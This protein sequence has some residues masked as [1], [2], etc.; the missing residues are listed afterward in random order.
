MAV[1]IKLALFALIVALNAFSALEASN[2][3]GLLTRNLAEQGTIQGVINN[4]AGQRLVNA[5]A[6]FY[7]PNGEIIDSV[8][9]DSNGL[10]DIS[11]PTG[12]YRVSA[13][14]DG[15][16]KE[17]YPNSYFYSGSTVIKLFSKQNIQISISLKEGGLING[18]IATHNPRANNCIVSAIKLDNPYINWQCDKQVNISENGEYRLGGLLAGHYRVFIRAQG[19][20][21]QYYPMVQDYNEAAIISIS[22][23]Q[24]VNNI[25]FD[26]IPPAY[27]QISGRVMDTGSNRP[28][29]DISI[30]ASQWSP[31]LNDPGICVALTDDNGFYQFETV[32]GDYVISA[33][34]GGVQLTDG[35]FRI[36]YDGRFSKD[37]AD[38]VALQSGQV[39]DNINLN[40]DYNRNYNLQIS[41]ALFDED[42]GAPI[43]GA[44]M[45]ALDY[46]TGRA[47]SSGATENSGDFLIRN[48]PD[49]TYLIQITGS[50]LI[51]V[52]WPGVWGW[53]QAEKIRVSG[54]S[55][56]L[57]NGGAITQDYG[58]P[59]L[60]ISG[61]VECPDSNLAN[62]RIYAINV[63]NDM[64]AF[65]KTDNFGNY[66]LS[67]GLTEGAYN[68][69]ADLY[70]F[71][72]TYYPGIVAIDLIDNPQVENINFMLIPTFLGIDENP[73]L[74]QRDELLTN[75]PNPFNGGTK[76]MFESKNDGQVNFEVY[77]IAGRLCRILS[78]SVKP[79]INEI[80]WDGR[81]HRGNIVASGIYFYRVAGT[82][83]VRKMSL[84]K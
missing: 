49:G 78:S 53:Q 46:F 80:Y 27:G 71:D 45:V 23:L 57:Y 76:I 11:L 44:R 79:G 28:L 58:T 59:G 62:V 67:S 37:L 25:D 60:S 13:W 42:D 77:D 24:T 66:T 9:S 69:Y 35:P 63:G 38:I 68:I 64:I 41:G 2:D 73:N 26:L 7:S 48:I 51:P 75:Y 21:I 29:N 33:M 55:A 20:Q 18:H 72:G 17:Y 52:F 3:P 31:D 5:I 16:I 56:D 10:F 19:Y 40:I 83:S 84:I 43:T 4:D 12:G 74:P 82:N 6:V 50:N 8:I 39:I 61:K 15:Y 32:A 30:F 47:L 54:A 70:G 81:D 36:Y 14:A 65:G 1:K 22:D 34:F